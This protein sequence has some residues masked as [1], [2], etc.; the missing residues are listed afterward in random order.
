MTCAFRP[1]RLTVCDQ[2]FLMVTR[3]STT[4]NPLRFLLTLLF[5]DLSVSFDTLGFLVLY[6][7]VL[8][9][10]FGERTVF[11]RIFHSSLQVSRHFFNGK[12]ERIISCFQI[13]KQC[14]T[15]GGV[16]F[17]RLSQTETRSGVAEKSQSKPQET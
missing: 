14:A 15:D 12:M 10:S 6:I 8:D 3:C 1:L 13:A 9:C 11:F 4:P 17:R 5:T 16:C 2:L 7:C